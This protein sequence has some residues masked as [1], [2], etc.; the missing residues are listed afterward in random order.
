M[1][2]A[3]QFKA[4]SA[5]EPKQAKK[6]PSINVKDK[7]Q[8]CYCGHTP[9]FLEN[10]PLLKGRKNQTA[11]DS[12]FTAW[13]LGYSQN[14]GRNLKE[15][16]HSEK[17]SKSSATTSTTV[18]TSTPIPANTISMADQIMDKHDVLELLGKGRYSHVVHIQCRRTQAH[19]ALKVVQKTPE[20]EGNSYQVEI[21]ILS[22][23]HHPSIVALYDVFHSGDKVYLFLELAAGGDLYDHISAQGCLS[24]GRG[25]AVLKMIVDGVSYL[26]GCGITHRDIKLENLLYKSQRE[27]APVLITDFG[28]AH[29]ASRSRLCSDDR[30]QQTDGS[31]CGAG[32]SQLANERGYG[33]VHSTVAVGMST[34][35]GTPEYMSP[36]MLEGEEYCDKVDMWAVGVVVYVMLSGTMP[37]V[38][39]LGK[40]GRARMYQDIIKGHYIFSDKVCK[41]VL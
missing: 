31:G 28:L 23:C 5:V 33:D 21:D 20:D 11:A 13:T 9:I 1:G 30:I 17:S 14:D 8:P 34:T 27:D 25:K 19:F 18:T 40:G 39:A 38:E 2:A 26:H 6:L 24:E 4:L 15:A 37:F 36:E 7:D 32:R 22:R 41:I 10:S 35:C 12:E 16:I 29:V 3:L